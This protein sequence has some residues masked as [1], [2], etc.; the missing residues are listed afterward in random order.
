MTNPAAVDYPSPDIQVENHFTLFLIWPLST[1]GE[2]WIQENVSQDSQR[3]GNALA[4]EPRYV[5]DIMQGMSAD[6]LIFA[7]RSAR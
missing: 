6:G 5:A 2:S 4:V 1:R 7:R 3:F